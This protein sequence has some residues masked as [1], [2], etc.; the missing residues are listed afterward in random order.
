MCC[1]MNQSGMLTGILGG[2]QPDRRDERG[3]A[4]RGSVIEP[5]PVGA[6]DGIAATRWTDLALDSKAP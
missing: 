4:R 2:S 3:I 6:L 1:H 5:R